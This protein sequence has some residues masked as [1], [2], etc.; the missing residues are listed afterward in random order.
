MIG[1][2]V[3]ELVKNISQIERED[4]SECPEEIYERYMLYLEDLQ[5][6]LNNVNSRYYQLNMNGEDG[7]KK[8]IQQYERMF[9]YELYHQLRLIIGEDGDEET[10]STLLPRYEGVMLNGEMEKTVNRFM[11]LFRLVNDKANNSDMHATIREA[12]G[13]KDSIM[14]DLI[15]HEANS[16]NLQIYMVEVK[17]N[18]NNAYRSDLEKLT[19]FKHAFEKYVKEHFHEKNP[20][21]LLYIFIYE[22][23]LLQKFQNMHDDTR[24]TF[25][26]QI[27]SNQIDSNIVCYYK[28][29]RHD[30]R[31]NTLKWLRQNCKNN[32]N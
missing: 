2:D 10:P 24:E 25:F 28:V 18:D 16:Y 8:I 30:Y 29:G 26:N 32:S 15:L 31:C 13:G 1:E 14:P 5:L 17:M 21:F 19:R 9:A 4:T 27:D 11:T 6:A 3:I 7:Q 22:G 20:G 12:F 23:N